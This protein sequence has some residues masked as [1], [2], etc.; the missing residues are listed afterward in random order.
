MGRTLNIIVEPVSG[1]HNYFVAKVADKIV[2]Q[3]EA[4]KMECDMDIPDTPTSIYV[5]SQGIGT[6]PKYKITLDIPGNTNDHSN[7]YS[8]IRGFHEVTYIL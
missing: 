1:T 6:G 4:E 5:S 7:T 2:M 8:L 3:G